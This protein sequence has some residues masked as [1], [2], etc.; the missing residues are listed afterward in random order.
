MNGAH[1]PSAPSASWRA[2]LASL[3]SGLARML[4]RPA[5][6]TLLKLE[7]EEVAHRLAELTDREKVP[8]PNR[9]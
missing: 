7:S 9:A 4:A 3:S 1:S 2:R 8:E 5:C 6:V